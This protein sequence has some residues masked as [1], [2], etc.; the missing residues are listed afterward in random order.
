MVKLAA[1]LSLLFTEL[2]VPERFAAAAASGFTGVEML[3]PYEDSAQDLRKATVMAGLEFVLLNCPPPNWTGGE[4]GFAAVPG[5]E[6]RFR[7]DFDRACRFADVLKARHIHIMAGK[8]A[9]SV[10]RATYVA[11]LQWAAARAPRRSLTIEP[12]NGHDMPGYF[13]NDF[14]QAA[15]ILDEVGAPNLG[16]QFDAYHAQMLTGD[17]LAVWAAHGHRAVHI[18]IAGT[19]GRFE[20]IPSDIDYPT[21]LRAIRDSGYAGW[22]S[23]EY[24]PR[25]VTG[26]GLGWIEQA[27]RGLG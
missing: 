23:A 4:R 1:N 8:A 14:D 24:N 5:A 18:Q 21:L 13:L 20:P 19:P 10:A 16:L 3:F 17:A 22:I 27:L 7:H 12:L 15:A 26:D 25:T 11:N 9:G 6:A 2:P